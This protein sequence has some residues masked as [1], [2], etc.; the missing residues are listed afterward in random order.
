MPVKIS[1]LK[2]NPNNPRFIRDEKFAQLVASLKALPKM[3]E[4]RPI[5]V[6]DN[7]IVQGGNMRLKAL[8]ELGYKE[9]PDT[10][11]KQAKD[12]TADEL[13]EFIIKD[14]V[15]YGEWDWDMIANEWNA[16]E[17]TE[18]GLDIPDFTGNTLEAENGKAVTKE[19]A[20]KKLSDVFYYT[21]LQHI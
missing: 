1:K 7:N 10:W 17:V 14:N 12:F 19:D 8:K 21:T 13:K 6:D 11:I 4:L 5:I 18:W 16:E 2:Q 3:M 20:H 9:I 15:G